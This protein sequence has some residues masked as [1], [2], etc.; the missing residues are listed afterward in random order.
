MFITDGQFDIT[1]YHQ[2]LASPAMDTQLLL[3]L[4]AYYREAIP[5]SKLY[6]QN[7]SGV[8][9]T[10]NELWR[11]WRDTRDSASVR[12]I[13]FD[14]AQ[15]VPDEAV[16]I[17][18]EEVNAYYQ[19]HRN[20][21]LR[22]A[23]AAVKFIALDRAP[24]A[25]DTAAALERTRTA[26]ARISGGESFEAVAKEI[27]ADSGSASQG[28]EITI[29]RAQTFPAFDQAAFSQPVGALG[30]PVLTQAGYHLIRVE[31]RTGD[32]ATVKHILVPIEMSIEQ[33]DALLDKADSLDALA[34]NMKL[35]AIAA[36]FGLQVR[37]AE[38]I[39]GLPFIAGIGQADEVEEWA[40]GEAR[41]GDVS[42][43]FETP[44]AYVVAEL[45]NKDAERTLTV[46]EADA[47]I[48][49]ALKANK[50]LEKAR[51]TARQALDRIKRGESMETVAAAYGTE[52]REAGPFTRAEYVPGLGRLTPAIGA[53]FGLK[54]GETSGVV[55]SERNLF[56]VRTTARK[57][58]DRAAW[59]QQKKD[60]RLRVTQALAEQRWNQ[61]V[62]ALKANAK[63]VD[64]RTKVLTRAADQSPI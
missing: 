18:P 64:D 9:V 3:D 32:E 54:P 8:Y 60:Q 27:S 33:E 16:S 13:V 6:F 38:M 34:E 5:R 23:R 21:F 61:F 25:V 47:S 39:P 26:R 50:K 35:D 59:E 52:A 12:Y 2:F 1:K 46:E 29:T 51:E 49:A 56:I 11:M 15:L 57:D 42:Q 45:Q 36:Q 30:E 58:A 48:R 62:A 28:G 31:S 20:E 37:Q 7:T 63:I 14:P 4:E 53:A 17:A 41:P 22:P 19:A 43:V 40:L 44:S 55:E 10:D 24:T